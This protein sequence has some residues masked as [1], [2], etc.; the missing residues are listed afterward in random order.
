MILTTDPPPPS[1]AQTIAVAVITAAL[2]AA[3]TQIITWGVDE[4]RARYGTAKRE[5]GEDQ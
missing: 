4:M 2:T 5:S 1:N 3:A